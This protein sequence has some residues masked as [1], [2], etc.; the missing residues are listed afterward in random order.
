MMLNPGSYTLCNRAISTAVT[1][2]SQTA[3]DL[4]GVQACSIEAQFAYGS[5][6]A[7]CKC[8]VQVSLDRGQTWIDIANF[9][10]TTASGVKVINLS[11]LTPTLAAFTPTD[12]GMADNTALDGILGSLMRAKV[13]SA[14]SYS[15]SFLAVR[16]DAR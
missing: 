7:S 11:G 3:I 10:F 15:N 12:T 9:A 4:T 1:G 14:G 13:T 6:G 8:W 16:V 5:G 2:E